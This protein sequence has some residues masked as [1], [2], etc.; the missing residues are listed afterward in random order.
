MTAETRGNKILVAFWFI[1]ETV[2]IQL[3]GEAQDTRSAWEWGS[4]LW[5]TCKSDR[6]IL[7]QLNITQ[8]NSFT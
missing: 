7:L 3:E 8:L 6:A 1:Q 4:P 5:A 2:N